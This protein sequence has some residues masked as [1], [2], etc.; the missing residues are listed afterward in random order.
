MAKRKKKM[1]VRRSKDKLA[2]NGMLNKPGEHSTASISASHC[3]YMP[4]N[5]KDKKGAFKI[6]NDLT[7]V[8]SDCSRTISLEF[9][10]RLH[11]SIDNS[12]YKA[13]AM[14]EALNIVLEQCQDAKRLRDKFNKKF[15]KKKK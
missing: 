8:I 15:A 9:D 5:V 12:I 14:I 2:F 6:W 7:L 1:T 13:E 3:K 10:M 11:D 4:Y